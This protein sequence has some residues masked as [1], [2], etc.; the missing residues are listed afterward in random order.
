[1]ST[2]F[3]YSLALAGD[4]VLTGD[5][6]GMLLAHDWYAECVLLEYVLSVLLSGEGLGIY[7]F[8]YVCM[9]IYIYI[10]IYI[11]MYV[12]IYIYICI[13]MY[14]YIDIIFDSGV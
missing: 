11:Y 12:Y 10:Y 7:V 8:M 14:I 3:I 13:Y 4:V 1:M 9:Y 2:N 5:G 6:Q